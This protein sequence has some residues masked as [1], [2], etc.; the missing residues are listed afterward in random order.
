MTAALMG[1]AGVGCSDPQSFV[2]VTVRSADANPI[3]NVTDLVVTVINAGN[4]KVL[5]YPAPDQAPFSITGTLDPAT[6]KIGKTL[7]VSFS[8]SR[9]NDVTIQIAARD[10]ARCTI[11][12]G[13][14]STQIKKGGIGSVDVALAH[15]SGPCEGVDGGTA[16]DGG[17]VLF[18]GCDPATASCGA[19]QTCAVDCMTQKGECVAAGS[20]P[21]GD[22][23]TKNADCQPGTQC[24]A[25]SGTCQVSACLKFCKTDSDCGAG[26]GSVCQGK[27][28]CPIGGT[29]VLTAY[30]TCTFGCDPRGA[31]ITGCPA[32]LH[33]FV[34]DTMDQVD[35]ACTE[36]SRTKQEGE[37][38]ALGVDCA[39]GL[40]CNRMN[41]TSICRTICKRSENSADCPSGHPTCTMLDG[42]QL[43]GACL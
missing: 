37:V 35:C 26:T 16:D 23:C 34:V 38:C 18:P 9:S 33:C 15:A 12:V 28:S 29:T 42:D 25:Y 22:V 10:A 43:Y 3:T 31:A 19:A 20:S 27:I 4:T 14:N 24:F 32:G 8:S 5:T 11:G 41:G 2:V 39:P 21:A 1:G 36:A 7:S 30:H 17:G 13:E 6:G 40:I